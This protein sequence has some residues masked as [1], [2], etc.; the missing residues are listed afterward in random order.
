M[1]LVFRVDFGNMTKEEGFGNG[2]DD[3]L[4]DGDHGKSITD[5]FS[6]EYLKAYYGS[7]CY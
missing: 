1:F 5:G 4:I 6:P 7:A 2:R 3:M